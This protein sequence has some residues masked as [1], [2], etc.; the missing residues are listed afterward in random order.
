M[1]SPGGATVS[2]PG[3]ENQ[4]RERIG[5][6]DLLLTGINIKSIRAIKTIP[7]TIPI[8][9][10]LAGSLESVNKM[11]VVVYRPLFKVKL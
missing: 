5:M 3:D 7:T 9:P 10:Y 8:S 2:R 6:M 1:L 4:T 11:H